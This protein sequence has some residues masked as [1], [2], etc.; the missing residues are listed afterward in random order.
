MKLNVDMWVNRV[1]KVM[2]KVEEIKNILGTIGMDE[3]CIM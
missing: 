2:D 1:L 3:E